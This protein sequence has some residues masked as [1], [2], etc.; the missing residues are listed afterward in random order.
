VR[1]ILLAEEVEPQQAAG[2]LG[3]IN[4]H[5]AQIVGLRGEFREHL[6]ECAGLLCPQCKAYVGFVSNLSGVC[7]HCGGKLFP[8]VF[9]Q[10]APG[11]SQATE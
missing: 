3:C 5:L 11:S 6:H 7:Y 4:L 1:Q 2:Y 8:S 10:A 9:E